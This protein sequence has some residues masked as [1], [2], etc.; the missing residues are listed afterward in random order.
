MFSL[1]KK[2]VEQP[3][4]RDE[5]NDKIQNM[6]EERQRHELEGRRQFFKNDA[7]TDPRFQ[8]LH[9]QPMTR[10]EMNDKIQKMM[11]E[12]RKPERIKITFS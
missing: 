12:R 7:S 2:Q 10:D 1:F 5:I 11:E 8:T 4:T 6:M 9:E 3:M